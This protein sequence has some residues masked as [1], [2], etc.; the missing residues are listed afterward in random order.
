MATLRLYMKS[1]NVIV[2]RG[3]KEWNVTWDYED[4]RLE[5][6]QITLTRWR[7][8]RGQRVV[9]TSLDLNQVECITI[10]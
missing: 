5:R 9:L 2:Q 4:D 8:L 7:I 6:L 3:V 10:S 1:G